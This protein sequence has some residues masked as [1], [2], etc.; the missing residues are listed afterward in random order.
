MLSNNAKAGRVSV[1]RTWVPASWGP[2]LPIW[3]VK[4]IKAP[5]TAPADNGATVLVRNRSAVVFDEAP[6][7]GGA[8]ASCATPPAPARTD[9]MS[10][11]GKRPCSH[12]K[13]RALMSTSLLEW[14]RGS[15]PVGLEQ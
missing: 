8:D 13:A 2:R 15:R 1:T 6:I 12:R 14:A 7:A 3:I 9:P 5:A 10:S 4:V 11:A